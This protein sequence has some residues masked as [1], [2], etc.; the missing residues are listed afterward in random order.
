MADIREPKLNGLIDDMAARIEEDL[1]ALYSAF[2][3]KL[4]KSDSGEHSIVIEE[5]IGDTFDVRARWYLSVIQKESQIEP[6]LALLGRAREKYVEELIE[7]FASSLPH[8]E[9]VDARIVGRISYWRAEA[10]R[11][12]RERAQRR[13]VRGMVP[14]D[15]TSGASSIA[16]SNSGEGVRGLAATTIEEPTNAEL[17]HADSPTLPSGP[18]DAMIPVF[19]A[20]DRLAQEGEHGTQALPPLEETVPRVSDEFGRQAAEPVRQ[21]EA[22]HSVN[23]DAVP[24][25][26]ADVRGERVLQSLV[27]AQAE[28]DPDLLAP[29]A[30]SQNRGP[31]A[32]QRNISGTVAEAPR[33]T[34]VDEVAGF[35]EP[36][37]SSD[38]D[39]FTDEVVDSTATANSG[40]SEA[41]E[42]AGSRLS[43]SVAPDSSKIRPEPEGSPA[44]EKAEG[45][46]E[47]KMPVDR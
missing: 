9:R 42:D 23:I 32:E 24:P 16:P 35:K 34:R 12:I 27:D 33:G 30:S 18:L 45:E 6:Y 2:V 44:P 41:Q 22:V 4:L 20:T 25:T 39:P 28:V 8:R 43:V 13:G 29:T 14:P 40:E 17:E 38:R 37:Q 15:A 36:A 19:P 7:H 21:M 5:Y 10:M 1:A 3:D 47:N 46:T 31:E 26:A 11:R